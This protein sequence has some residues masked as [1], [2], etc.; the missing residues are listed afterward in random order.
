M[1]ANCSRSSRKQLGRSESRTLEGN[2][3]AILICQRAV[4]QAIADGNLVLWMNCVWITGVDSDSQA[5]IRNGGRCNRLGLACDGPQVVFNW[6][7]TAQL[8]CGEADNIKREITL[9]EELSP[10]SDHDC[11]EFAIFEVPL[12]FRVRL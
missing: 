7:W 2:L 11:E 1:Q 12:R 6:R 8:K 4:G 9:T 5:R 10:I 3:L